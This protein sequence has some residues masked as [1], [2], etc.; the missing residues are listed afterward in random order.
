[1]QNIPTEIYMH[2]YSFLNIN[3][4][5]PIDIITNKIIKSN[6]IWESR[7]KKKFDIKDSINYYKEYKWQ[8]KLKKHQLAYK[9]QYTLGCVGKTNPLFKPT[10][11]PP[12]KF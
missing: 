8:L 6:I 10:W 1:M 5:K 7:T 9:R 12:V 2:I 11:N 4:L 3:E